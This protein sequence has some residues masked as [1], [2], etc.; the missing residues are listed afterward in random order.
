MED[1]RK[2]LKGKTIADKMRNFSGT[3][4]N[5]RLREAAFE[6]SGF[7]FLKSDFLQHL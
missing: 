4:K 6:G 5:T 1:K 7:A 3:A 2:M